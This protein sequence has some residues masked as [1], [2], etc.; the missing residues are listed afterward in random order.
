MENKNQASDKKKGSFSI[1]LIIALLLVAVIVAS[2][3]IFLDYDEK[4]DLQTEISATYQRLDSISNELSGKIAE[5]EKLGGDVAELE[6]IRKG[7]ERDKENLQKESV[8]RKRELDGYKDKVE[9]YEELLKLQDEK[10]SQL[11]KINQALMQENTGLK[12]DKNVMADSIASLRRKEREL[13]SKV[14]TAA[15]LKAENIS[16]RA[17]N[18]RGREREGEFRSKQIEQLQIEFNLSDN[19]VAPIAGRTIMLVI[20]DP[21]NNVLFDVTRG[22]GTFMIA[23]KEYFYTLKQEILF[24]NSRQKLSFMYEKMS[25]YEPGLYKVE[26]YA[27]DYLI[28]TDQFTVK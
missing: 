12:K 6:I 20:Y 15:R 21:Y 17:V 19:K 11:E 25:D 3:K 18:K 28:G 10:I 7:L 24:D 13:E 8:R 2:I 27:E 4:Q 9:G 23:G 1:A 26:L 22:S 16:V 14:A 5:I